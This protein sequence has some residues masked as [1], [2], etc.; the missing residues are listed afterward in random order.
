MAGESIGFDFP[1]GAHHVLSTPAVGSTAHS[2]PHGHLS[3]RVGAANERS[4]GPRTRDDRFRDDSCMAPPEPESNARDRS[5][6]LDATPRAMGHANRGSRPAASVAECLAARAANAHL[7]PTL[8][9]SCF[10]ALLI[11]GVAEGTKRHVAEPRTVN[12]HLDGFRKNDHAQILSCLT[13][14]IKWTVF[15]AFQLTGKEA[16][17]RAIDGAPEFIDPPELTIA[18]A[19]RA[20]RCP[21]RV[22]KTCLKLTRD[23]R[24]I[25][26]VSFSPDVTHGGICR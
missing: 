1:R 9:P 10:R 3:D 16:Y 11:T 25:A 14:D 23:R 26:P 4:S 18:L 20:A 7:Q 17:D 5:A 22:T 24:E 21:Y 6:V 19:D 15:G 8:S 2:D 13:D 12:T